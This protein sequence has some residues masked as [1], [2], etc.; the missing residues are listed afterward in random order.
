MASAVLSALRGETTLLLHDMSKW[1]VDVD[2]MFATLEMDTSQLIANP[3]DVA[4][5]LHINESD[6][7]TLDVGKAIVHIVDDRGKKTSDKTKRCFSSC[8]Y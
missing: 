5:L 4:H 2:R 8:S 3:Y 6:M 1:D 7:K